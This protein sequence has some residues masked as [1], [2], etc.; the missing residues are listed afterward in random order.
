[1]ATRQEVA[2]FLSDFKSAVRGGLCDYVP[3]ARNAQGLIDL[4]LKDF[5]EADP[6]L[7]GLDPDDY[8]Q[9]PEPDADRPGDDIWVFG[10]MVGTTEAYIKVKLI[11]DTRSGIGVR[12]KVL[13]FHAADRPLAHPLRGGGT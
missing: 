6:I 4:G 9:G 13:S 11:E 5:H 8:C 7:L 2:G 1:M 12:A 10:A 3:R